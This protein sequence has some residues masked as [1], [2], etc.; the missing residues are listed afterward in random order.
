VFKLGWLRA[1]SFKRLNINEPFRFP[2]GRLL[3]VGRNESGKSTVMEAIHYALFGL[4]LRPSKKASNEDI[5]AYGQPQAVVELA[6]TVNDREYNVKR[7]LRRRGVN[8]HELSIRLPDGKL[9]RV[10]GAREVNK[11][12]EEELHGIDS[13]ALLNSCLVEQK[14]LGKLEAATRSERVKAM[15]NLLNIEAFVFAA[16]SLKDRHKSLQLEHLETGTRLEVAERAKRLYEDAEKK[17]ADSKN[18]LSKIT[19]ELEV[20]YRK[21]AELEAAIAALELMKQADTA[22]KH[23]RA[24]LTGLRGL[25]KNLEENIIKASAAAKRSEDLAREAPAAKAKLAEADARMAALEQLQSFEERTREGQQRLLVTTQRLTDVNARVTEAEEAEREAGRLEEQSRSLEPAREVQRHL[26]ELAETEKRVEEIRAELE[27]IRQEDKINAERIA[28]LTEA[29]S[30][31]SSLEKG[32][33]ESEEKESAIRRRRNVGVVVAAIGALLSLTYFSMGTIALLGLLLLLGGAVVAIRSNPTTQHEKLG[34]LQ[35]SRDRL[36]GERSRIIEYRAKAQ[37]V[38]S[39]ISTREAELAEAEEVH[40]LAF[41]SLPTQPR[42]YQEIQPLQSLREAVADDLERLASITALLAEKRESAS[43]L[44]EWTTARSHLQRE[45]GDVE[46]AI[47]AIQ[48]EAE[49]LRQREGVSTDKTQETRVEREQALRAFSNLNA[50]LEAARRLSAELPQIRSELEGKRTEMEEKEAEGTRLAAEAKRIEAEAG[51]SL[52]DEPR[53]AREQREESG[54]RGRLDKEAEERG[55]DILEAEQVISDN[56]DLK[57]EHPTLLER[58]GTEGFELQSLSLAVRILD[59]TRDRIMAGVKRSVEANMASFLPTLTD[60][61]YNMARIDEERYLIEVY[62]REAKDWRS[63]GVFS[64][65]AQDQFSL[66]LRLAFALSTIPSTRGSRPGFIFLDEPLSS[67]D[68]QRRAGFLRL[69][70]EEL[71]RSFDQIIVI[72]HVEQLMEEF[73]NIVQL[74]AGRVVA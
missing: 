29:E 50:E 31:F 58:H 28:S 57:E 42:P 72:T 18:R 7:V 49:A 56:R 10:R 64:G 14:E 38:R 73:L 12:I 47:A 19:E 2:D 27:R 65:G 69:L 53:L 36:L 26:G 22:A 40:A 11:R 32:I 52:A 13:E 60:G 66:A 34:N 70:R 68:S 67:F 41:S 20:V 45:R 35:Q 51:V 16:E 39:S 59:A 23:A 48:R 46:E 1:S 5:I 74:E 9:D 15:T 43:K 25:V 55:Q 62:D 17:N 4:A 30:E 37:E 63:K 21:L 71:T 24:E 54:R 6:F 61:R 8:D 33:Q 44:A 3:I